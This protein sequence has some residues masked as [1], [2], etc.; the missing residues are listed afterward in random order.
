MEMEEGQQMDDTWDGRT[1]GRKDEMWNCCDWRI[2]ICVF[3]M[4]FTDTR[5]TL[6]LSPGMMDPLLTE[7]VIARAADCPLIIGRR[8]ER[9]KLGKAGR[10]QVAT[11][12]N[13]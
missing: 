3:W 5:R 13:P 12:V 9:V 11:V 2:Y 10:L 8:R 6:L 7:A 1:E 4:G